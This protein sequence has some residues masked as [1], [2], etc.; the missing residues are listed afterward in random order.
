[1][2][3]LFRAL[4][5]TAA[6][7]LALN[8]SSAEPAPTPKFSVPPDD[9]PSATI[10]DFKITFMANGAFVLARQGKYLL[11]GG[12]GFSLAGWKRWGDQMR[13][14]GF[15]AAYD[16]LESGKGLTFDGELCD[17]AG[18]RTFTLMQKVSGL[19]GG[20]RFE[21]AIQP[22]EELSLP[23]L[24]P[25]FHWPATRF[26]GQDLLLLPGFLSGRLSKKPRGTLLFPLAPSGYALLMFRNEPF[27]AIVPHR[28]ATW[29]ALDDRVFQLN[30]G[31][32][33]CTPSLPKVLKKGRPVIVGFDLHLPPLA[34]LP[35]VESGAALFQLDYVGVGH[36]L[37]G[38]KRVA[39]MGLCWRAKPTESWRFALAVPAGNSPKR[40][41]R[42]ISFEGKEGT[43]FGFGVRAGAE[44]NNFIVDWRAS[45]LKAALPPEMGVWMLLPKEAKLAVLDKTSDN[46]PAKTL[47][48]EIDKTTTLGVECEGEWSHSSQTLWG[49]KGELAVCPIPTAG[50]PAISKRAVIVVTHH[51]HRDDAAKPLSKEG[52]KDE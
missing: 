47:K 32:L 43:T 5:F 37:V 21:Y 48:V 17:L 13:A 18:K 19:Q 6:F 45:V 33:W 41:D 28:A 16:R 36:I 22:M 23:H 3:L 34:P 35:E 20:L 8:A 51:V 4:A 42:G 40:Q 2:R 26:I 27:V 1:M 46:A 10:G 52:G 11:D 30:V 31:R 44:G 15:G 50:Q 38:R 24:G 49:A 12:I 25:T 29:K 7:C 39:Q 9:L 14:T